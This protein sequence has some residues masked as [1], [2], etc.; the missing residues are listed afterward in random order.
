[1]ATK[2]KRW[3]PRCRAVHDDKCPDAPVWQKP[4]HQKSGRGGRPWR[5]KRHETFEEDGYQCRECGR[6]VTLH[7]A[8]AGICDHIV[9]LCEGGTD[10]K[11]NRQT[12]C[13]PCSDQKT[14]LESQRGRG[15]LKP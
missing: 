1:M 5:R 9:P 11:S 15:G 4:V 6:I 3:C 2:P 7:G 14:L 10:T 13:K 8:L 12:L